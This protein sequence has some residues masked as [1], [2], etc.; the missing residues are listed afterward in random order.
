MSWEEKLIREY[1]KQK[2]R[3][4]VNSGQHTKKPKQYLKTRKP[5]YNKHKKAWLWKKKSLF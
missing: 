5:I 4:E 2:Y 1:H 3:E